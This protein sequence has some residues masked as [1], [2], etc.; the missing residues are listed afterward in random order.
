LFIASLVGVF[1]FNEM[2]EKYGPFVQYKASL[3]NKN[4]KRD[5]KIAI[6]NVAG[7]ESHHVL[8]L[9]SYKSIDEIVQELKEADAKLNYNSKKILEGHL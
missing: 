8:F 4:I 2:P 3:E 9:S 5:E 6:L 1:K 7:T